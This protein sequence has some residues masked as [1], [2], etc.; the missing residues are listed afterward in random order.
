MEAEAGRLKA[1]PAGH[2]NPAVGD[3][4]VREIR[5]AVGAHALGVLHELAERALRLRRVQLSAD[6]QQVVA[7]LVGR[8]LLAADG[9]IVEVE[10]AVAVGVGEVR[11]AVRAHAPRAGERRLLTRGPS[12][13]GGGGGRAACRCQQGYA[14]HRGQGCRLPKPLPSPDATAVGAVLDLA[15]VHLASPLWPDSW[16]YQVEGK[17]G[18][19]K[20]TAVTWLS[21]P[22]RLLAE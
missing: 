14:G 15:S 4:R 9:A 17:P 1:E 5:H 18:D 3:L 2:S 8:R 7:D 11:H 6:I 19:T 21:T 16:R 12:R 13:A 22:A 20:V 10:V